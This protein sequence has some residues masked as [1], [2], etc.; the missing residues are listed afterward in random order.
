MSKF[1]HFL[2]SALLAVFFALTGV[3]FGYI[4]M[5]EIQQRSLRSALREACAEQMA[6]R[7]GQPSNE[8][9]E[10]VVKYQCRNAIP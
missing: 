7:M 3:I 5:D 2:G 4:A 8:M 1:F 6:A 10:L 9:E